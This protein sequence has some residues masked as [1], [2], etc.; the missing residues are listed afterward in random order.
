M[1]LTYLIFALPKLAHVITTAKN[2]IYRTQKKT[3]M[4][5]DTIW[6][7]TQFLSYR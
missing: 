7:E 1:L 3:E 2:Q 5:F 6:K 4:K